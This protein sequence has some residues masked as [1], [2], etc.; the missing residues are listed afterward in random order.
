MP[1]NL[2]PSDYQLEGDI[3][4]PRVGHGFDQQCRGETEARLLDA[5]AR[6]VDR[7]IFSKELRQAITDCS[8]RYYL[9]AARTNLLRPF[10]ERLRGLRVLEVGAECGS[11]TRFFGEIGSTVVAIEPNIHHAQIAR[12]RTSEFA[13]V[14]L[15]CDDIWQFASKKHFNAV[16]LLSESARERLA[17]PDAHR[18][19]AHVRELIEPTGI[20][21]IAANN[22]H[23]L[24][25]AAG[26]EALVRCAAPS[27]PPCGSARQ[28]LSRTLRDCGFLDQEWHYPVPNS[29]APSSIFS[30]ECF[31]RHP[32][33]ALNMMVGSSANNPLQ[34]RDPSVSQKGLLAD[35][36]NAFLVLAVPGGAVSPNGLLADLVSA[37]MSALA[38]GTP[39]KR[40]SLA[41]HFSTARHPA[42]TKMVH[43]SVDA[44]NLV[45]VDRSGLSDAPAPVSSFL[46]WRMPDEPFLDGTNWLR[47]LVAILNTAGWR[48]ADIAE[49]ARPWV[50]ALTREARSHDVQGEEAALISGEYFDAVPFNLIKEPSGSFE[51]I[52]QEW[53]LQRPLELKFVVYRGLRES[54]QRVRSVASPGEGT[55]EEPTTL[56]ISV[57][58]D[59]GFSLSRQDL[60][61]YA[62][63]EQDVQAAVWGD[64]RSVAAL[65]RA[66]GGIGGHAGVGP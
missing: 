29:Q 18:L 32:E 61:R 39:K 33:L 11:L 63:L 15:V 6:A 7:S 13:N 3:W 35:L 30:H 25:S 53:T 5:V 17:G 46:R 37:F 49:W 38:K 64:E 27:G 9:D 65:P 47:K 56:I 41:W 59:L 43:F 19:L 57:M 42:F 1:L 20:A 55:P 10:T 21:I 8:S 60:E 16:V 40:R 54:F 45:A 14:H 52:D 12:V 51:F 26:S 48:T 28:E 22:T 2:F 66:S 31:E 44:H 34:D 50:D 4:T 23:G 36:A 62:V 24:Q 58:T